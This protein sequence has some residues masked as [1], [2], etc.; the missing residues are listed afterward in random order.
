M[1]G[2]G[3]DII[4]AFTENKSGTI[5]PINYT[6][7]VFFIAIGF[8]VY[9][10]WYSSRIISYIKKS[11]QEDAFKKII[12]GNGES[13]GKAYNIPHTIFDLGPHFLDELP[14]IIGHS[15]FLVLELAVLQS[16]ILT[17]PLGATT[18]WIIFIVS[19]ILIRF[20]NN[21]ILTTQAQ[22]NSFRKLFWISLTLLIL[23]IIIASLSVFT[24]LSILTLLG[25]LILFHIVFIFYINLRR[26]EVEEKG[27]DIKKQEAAPTSKV[28]RRRTA[29]EKI[30]DFFCV[31]RKETGYFKFFLYIGLAGIV[32]YLLAI[33]WLGFARS[34]GPFPF[35]ILA[36]AVLLAFG[37]IV[38]ALSIRFNVNFHFILLIL[39]FILGFGETHFVRTV[40]PSGNDNNYA[41][42]PQLNT[43][44]TAW[45]N[46][47]NVIAD[48]NKEYD[49]YFVMANGGASRSGY[50]T[51][52]VL[53]KI[54]DSSLVNSPT[55]RFSDHVFCLSG[56][57]GGGVGVATFF[58]L[59][60]DK[61]QHAKPL[62]NSSARAFLKQDYFTYTFARMLG[63]DFFNYIFHFSSVKDRAAA[64]EIS[65]EHSSRRNADSVYQ[66][67][68]YDTLNRFPAM[69]NGKVYMPVLFVNTTR[70]QDG[71]PGVVTNLK[72]DSSTF[73]NRV[74]V[75]RL[76]NRNEDISITSGS[77]LGARFPY[78]SP[79]GRIANNYFVDGGYFDNSGAGVVQ[80]II[81]GIINIAKDDSIRNGTSGRIYQQVRKLH[82]KVLH[83]VNSP[84]DLGSANIKKIA[85]I[86]NDLMAPILT[87]IGAYDMQTTVNDGRLINFIKDIDTYTSNRADYTQISLYKDTIEWKHDPLKVRFDEEPAYPMNW[88]MSDTTLRR[89][90]N[91]LMSNR[92]LD[93]IIGAMKLRH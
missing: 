71:N 70:M 58:S 16:P 47:R 60:R 76:L 81:R 26:I 27:K 89:V 56:T 15:C 45:L 24:N 54:E 79:A 34:I 82:F 17:L 91:R 49:V 87:I 40:K 28:I 72:L 37:N 11:T 50:W 75:L 3:K 39:A 62:Y 67:P 53:G 36:F 46:D 66:V 10:S 18:A 63:P 78:L 84:A 41:S 44:L 1:L 20:L 52:S 38:T 43:Y 31:P 21:W 25:L 35:I 90:D 92:K 64:L 33:N 74:D 73:N 77:I 48:S 2:Q 85:P 80:E 93:S 8:W 29:L 22:K 55:N 59:L 65:F 6:R 13:A 83:I 86:K 69:R 12:A 51:A 88:F 30:M 4:V 9:V 14:R 5:P 68:F 19:L 23:L 61:E 7:I 32:F 42:R 57:S